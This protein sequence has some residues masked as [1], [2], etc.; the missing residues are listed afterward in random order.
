MSVE[1]SDIS[2]LFSNRALCHANME[3]WSAALRW[4]SV[5]IRLNED[6]VK[7]AHRQAEA[8]CHLENS[9]GR[10]LVLLHSRKWPAESK[11]KDFMKA[12]NIKIKSTSSNKSSDFQ[13]Q[14]AWCFCKG[15]VPHQFPE[16]TTG[17]TWRELK[18]SGTA[19]FTQKGYSKAE[20][21]YHQASHALLQNEMLAVLVPSSLH[22]SLALMNLARAEEDDSLLLHQSLLESSVAALLDGSKV[23]A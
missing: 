3:D 20:V 21:L 11:L 14:A 10:N 8:L 7:A 6:N 4:A 5:A 23:K 17:T 2:I 16:D 19:A 15:I 18:E 12:K 22:R 9:A 1:C 13:T